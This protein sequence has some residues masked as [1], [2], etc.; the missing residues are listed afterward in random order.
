[1]GNEINLSCCTRLHDSMRELILPKLIPPFSKQE[2]IWCCCHQNKFTIIKYKLGLSVN[3]ESNIHCYWQYNESAEK[4]PIY[5]NIIPVCECIHV[6]IKGSQIFFIAH[7]KHL[8]SFFYP[9][10]E[11]FKIW[12]ILLLLNCTL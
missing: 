3:N 1:M 12:Y 2:F 10:N 4:L 5:I 8:Y 7:H 9:S 11:N 6:H